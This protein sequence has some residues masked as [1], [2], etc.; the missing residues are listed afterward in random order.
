LENLTWRAF[1]SSSSKAAAA[2]AGEG[3]DAAAAAPP[4]L[5]AI[6][7]H[8]AVPWGGNVVLVGGHMKVRCLPAGCRRLQ[9]L[10]QTLS[11]QQLLLLPACCCCCC[12]CCCCWAAMS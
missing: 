1:P 6:A 8:V 10:L 4:V 2:A 5:P 3:G 9:C 12:C 11:L 7:G